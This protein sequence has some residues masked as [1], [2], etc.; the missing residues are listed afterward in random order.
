[1]P[2]DFCFDFF[3]FKLSHFIP[4]M[5]PSS[6][7]A[8]VIC[9]CFVS[10]AQL[11]RLLDNLRIWLH[12]FEPTFFALLSTAKYSL[13]ASYRRRGGEKT[14]FSLP[15][16][17]PPPENV[18]YCAWKKSSKTLTVKWLAYGVQVKV[19]PILQWK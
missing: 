19:Q 1:M 15:P 9:S 11:D 4:K 16:Q 13:R 3:F 7:C 12:Y 14:F 10:N 5:L 18:K 17:P 2:R 6:F 8:E